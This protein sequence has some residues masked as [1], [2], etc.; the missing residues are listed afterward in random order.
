MNIKDFLNKEKLHHAYLIEGDRASIH[1]QI[2]YFL[3]ELKVD[4]IANPDFYNL[5][6]DSFKIDD[7]RNLKAITNE[8]SFA[9]SEDSKKIFLISANNFLLEAQNTLLKIFEE[10]IPNTHF[11][12][13]TPSIQIFIPTLLSRFYVIKTSSARQG[14]D[15]NTKEAE[16]FIKMPLIK[17]IEFLKEFLAS[18]EDDEEE[19][20]KDSPRS[21][22]LN[23][24]DSLETVLHDKKLS[25][26][27]LDIFEQIFKVRKYLRQP[28]SATKSLMESVALSI[29]E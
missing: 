29:P 9:I 20:T 19:N 3:E 24:L 12:I 18:N 28:G 25:N 22:A 10:P 2:F 16:N 17:R 7:A 5:S 23:F 8:K 15:E 4:T 26:N 11:F 27:T 21:R 14:L 6:L 1:A 13:V